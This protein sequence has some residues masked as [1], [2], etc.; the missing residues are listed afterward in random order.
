MLK[1]DSI[2]VAYGDVQ[3]LHEVSLAALMLHM[4]MSKFYMKFHWTSKR[5]NL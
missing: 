5:V 2:D 3:V 1:V 4:E